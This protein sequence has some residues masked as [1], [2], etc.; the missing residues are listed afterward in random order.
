MSIKDHEYAQDTFRANRAQTDN[1][2]SNPAAVMARLAA[3]ENDLAT[4][5]NPYEQ[6]ASDRAR[7]TRDW[8]KRIASHRITAKGNDSDARRAAALGAAIAQDD[9]YER[10][11]DAEARFESLKVVTRLLETRATIG[12]SILRSQGRA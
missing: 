6:A 5:Q 8:E 3:I 12:M 10:L 7:L 11:M 9:L 2:H 4:R 1:G